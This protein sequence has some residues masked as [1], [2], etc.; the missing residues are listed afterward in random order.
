MTG[1]IRRT[2]GRGWSGLGGDLAVRVEVTEQQ[3]YLLQRILEGCRARRG[4]GTRRHR[5]INAARYRRCRRLLDA[6]S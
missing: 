6:V 5:A 4:C 1:E 3:R 2:T